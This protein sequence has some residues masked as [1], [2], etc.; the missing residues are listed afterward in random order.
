MKK[1]QHLFFDLDHTLWDYDRNSLEVLSLLY[2]G[3]E[4]KER[5]VYVFD[6]FIAQYNR[7]NAH[8]WSQFNKS[9][10][11][12]DVI[13]KQRFKQVLSH[14]GIS[15]EKLANDLSADFLFQC[16]RKT[17][18]MPKTRETL[19][20][21]QDRYHLHILT[22]G[23]DDV[24]LLKLECSGLRTYFSEII[25]SDSVGAKK[26]SG[27]IFEYALQ[28]AGADKNGSIMIGDNLQTDILGARN[29]KMDQVFYNPAGKRHDA[30][31]TYEINCLSSMQKI[32]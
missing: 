1:Y 26:P 15:D 28:K 27:E 31:V 22:N 9:L 7:V 20:W 5:G 29:I 8:L 16:P 25:T 13:R 3:Y 32:F 24:Q 18:L 2:Q 17:H 11:D 19:G 10:I 30:A 12:R 14:Y 23:F 21:L 4:L 6:D